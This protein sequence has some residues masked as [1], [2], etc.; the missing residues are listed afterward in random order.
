MKKS[1]KITLSILCASVIIGIFVVTCVF[2]YKYQWNLTAFWWSWFGITWVVD[3]LVGCFIFYRPNRTDETKM[4][5]LLVMVVLP[6]AGA[7]IA[8]IYNYKLKTNYAQPNNDHSKLQ[9]AIFQAKESIKV[10]SDSFLVSE[11]TFKALNYA[12]WKDVKIQLI[13]TIQNKKWKQKF[14]VQK[15]QKN[16]DENIQ[17]FITSK[18]ITNSFVIIDDKEVIS[19]KN[20]FNF[21]VIYAS[22]SIKSDTNVAPYLATWKN[23]IDRCSFIS[24]KTPKN[25]IFKNIKF[26]LINIFYAFL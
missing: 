7:A 5:W 26:K 24:L 13:V 25:N 14:L 16:L 23:D 20:N 6:V 8:L 9:A 2:T 15:L 1:L 18:E 11:D 10:Y 19:S 3:I 17:L 21:N 22:E 4:F 12:R